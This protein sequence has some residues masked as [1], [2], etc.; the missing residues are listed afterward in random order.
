[1]ARRVDSTRAAGMVVDA[2][3][4]AE[5]ARQVH[6]A[7]WPEACSRAPTGSCGGFSQL[8]DA[9]PPPAGKLPSVRVLSD[10]LGLSGPLAP[11]EPRDVWV[12]QPSVG[13]CASLSSLRTA[14]D[15]RVD[16]SSAGG[17]AGPSH[18]QTALAWMRRFVSAFP[19]RRL[20]VPHEG[21]GDVK[22]AAYNEETLRLFGEFIRQH[23]SVR[24]GHR[25]ETVSASTIADY[26][27]AV[28]AHRSTQA[29]YNLLIA[30]GNLRL[31]KQLRHMR[32]EDGPQGRR[33][34][35]R[36]LTARY[37][38]KLVPVAGF[39]RRT[40]YG[41]MRWAVL[42]MAHNLLLRG[43]EVGRPEGRVFDPAA[44][45]TLADLDWISPCEETGGYEVLLVE[46]MPIKDMRVTR[47]RVPLLIRRRGVG[48]FSGRPRVD[49]ACA[50]EAVRAWWEL[51]AAECQPARWGV[52]P[53][54]AMAD[55]AAVYTSQVMEMVRQAV[56]AVGLQASEFD[57]HSMRIGGATDLYY[58]FEGSRAASFIQKRGRWCSLIHQIYERLSASTSMHVSAQMVEADGVDMESFKQGYVMDAVCR[59]QS[60]IV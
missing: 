4:A 30:G 3:E 57:S 25:G 1:M 23:G 6:D 60:R 36:G 14:A 49:V 21:A 53:L 17:M 15:R 39:E 51:R 33:S 54:F 44:G 52:E 37:L 40:R 12:T 13:E 9:M 10:S 20:F 5:V 28:R 59:G 29:G 42:W 16:C 27:S 18:L 8:R 24:P 41:I 58:L 34:L 46:V 7:L 2:D 19:S 56:G 11:G 22:A 50:W 38:R 32:R 47:A 43:G 55:G 35:T 31:P 45:I 48:K 26:I